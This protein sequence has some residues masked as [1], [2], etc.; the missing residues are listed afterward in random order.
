MMESTS[1]EEEGYEGED[2]E[3][4]TE[5]EGKGEDKEEEVD[6]DMRKRFI[7]STCT[8]KSLAFEKSKL[9]AAQI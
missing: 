9:A 2:D 1:E 8:R 7:H 5:G 4:E 6:E 3:E